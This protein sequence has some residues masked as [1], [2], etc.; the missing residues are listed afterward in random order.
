MRKLT[1]LL[2]EGYNYKR[3]NDINVDPN[4]QKMIV[5]HIT[6]KQY[7]PSSW[8]TE[9]PKSEKKPERYRGEDKAERS[10]NIL[11]RLA[12]KEKKSKSRFDRTLKGQTYN[13]SDAISGGMYSSG[14]EFGVGTGKHHGPGLYT[15]YKFNPSIAKTYG[16]RLGASVLQF[17]CST[18]NMLI[19]NGKLCQMIRGRSMTI[20]EQMDRIIE[21]KGLQ[22]S[23]SV[24][25]IYNNWK[26]NVASQYDTRVLETS[27]TSKPRSA[28][29]WQTAGRQFASMFSNSLL[30]RDIVDSVLLDGSGDGPVVVLFDYKTPQ[31]IR[32]GYIYNY[33]GKDA[34]K[35]Y[36]DIGQLGS[37]K[38]RVPKKDLALAKEISETSEEDLEK[39]QFRQKKLEDFVRSDINKLSIQKQ[40][41]Q[42][43]Q[44]ITSLDQFQK[45]FNNI[46]KEY[47]QA[48]LNSR[49]GIRM[50]SKEFF[51]MCK[52]LITHE[53]ENE[54]SGYFIA[55]D[56]FLKEIN[57]FRRYIST[58][59]YIFNRLIGVDENRF[60]SETNRNIKV[61][62][63]AI[64]CMQT[65]ATAQRNRTSNLSLSSLVSTL[66]TDELEKHDMTLSFNRQ[67]VDQNTG[68]ISLLLNDYHDAPKRIDMFLKRL[69]NILS[70]VENIYT[71]RS[72]GDTDQRFLDMFTDEITSSIS[73]PNFNEYSKFSESVAVVRSE[74]EKL[75]I[76]TINNTHNVV[77]NSLIHALD[78]NWDAEIKS[79][80]RLLS[81]VDS[82]FTRQESF[83]DGNIDNVKEA[84]SHF[85]K[86][87]F[88]KND[89]SSSCGISVEFFYLIFP[90]LGE[91]IPFQYEDDALRPLLSAFDEVFQTNL[92]SSS[93]YELQDFPAMIAYNEQDSNF[94][95]NLIKDISIDDV[96]KTLIH[97]KTLNYIS[98][99]E[100]SLNDYQ[101]QTSPNPTISSDLA[102]SV[103]NIV[104]DS[105]SW[106][107]ED[108]G[109][110]EYACEGF[111]LKV[112][113]SVSDVI[114][115]WQPGSVNTGEL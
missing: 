52:K 105:L 114:S 97:Q 96:K 62:P 35:W 59:V 21:N 103:L 34:V 66:Y 87:Q 2:F 72:R 63:I 94:I 50:S 101:V 67:Q 53:A 25:E 23:P 100:W 37:S 68:E 9:V 110:L 24:L 78:R 108:S 10:K 32:A 22:L 86:D 14:N 4:T 70:S 85:V 82:I 90:E 69:S 81:N 58:N 73:Q 16:G 112:L 33:K 17:E 89:H 15:C 48:Y 3:I 115:R 84:V 8:S 55:F 20:G 102:K 41:A 47:N 54:L 83:K 79:A 71:Q 40:E 5:Y 57:E 88:G 31:L 43:K 95:S 6:G 27:H 39:E 1:N 7:N 30:G 61:L 46:A 109:D 104:N 92:A 28:D 26:E 91:K 80:K 65:I 42:A 107:D 75:M 98:Y 19:L 77:V 64:K 60:Q 12:Y 36:E 18:E 56:K 106:N 111:N 45:S 13:L 29:I 74:Y 38:F 93:N 11:D 99:F 76:P 49:H 44:I 113:K 51:E